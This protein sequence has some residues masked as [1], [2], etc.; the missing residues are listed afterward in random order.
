M[1]VL[2]NRYKLYTYILNHKTDTNITDTLYTIV[3]DTISHS[4]L[5]ASFLTNMKVVKGKIKLS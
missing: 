2:Q 4:Y 5:F 3:Y 1:C